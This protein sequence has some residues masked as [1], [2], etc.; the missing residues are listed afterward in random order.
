M[1]RNDHVGPRDNCTIICKGKSELKFIFLSLNNLLN[2]K[3]ILTGK[4]LAQVQTFV[5]LFI[6]RLTLHVCCGSITGVY[7]TKT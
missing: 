7:K 5:I 3:Y 1:S 6:F 2:L 4:S